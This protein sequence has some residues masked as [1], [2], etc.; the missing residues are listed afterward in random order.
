MTRS[1]PMTLHRI[2]AMH[3]A[4]E[5]IT[6]LT[7]YDASFAK[8]LDTAGVDVLLVGD[9]LGMV[10]QGRPTTIPVSMDDMV[11]HTACVARGNETAWIIADMPFGSY[12]ESVDQALRNAVRL[13]QAGAHMVKLEGGG[14]TVPVVRFL[15]QRG[16]PV[17][18]HIGFTQQSV[19]MLGGFRIQ[20]R[21]EAAVAT[22]RAQARELVA[23]G[24]EG[25]ILELIPS[26]VA[27]AVT[28]ELPVPTI[29]HPKFKSWSVGEAA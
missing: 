5:K 2:R 28:L 6:M 9:S 23:A 14:W 22:L 17:Y 13:M 8:V 16:I 18:G 15:V 21:E 25:M 12:H 4:G 3:A 20:G 7:C 24:V 19:H 29:R 1:K 26:A 11:Y 10:L 27:R